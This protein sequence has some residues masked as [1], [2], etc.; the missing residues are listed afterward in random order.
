MNENTS[1]VRRHVAFAIKLAAVLVAVA[2]LLALGRR[3]GY[4][5][6]ESVMRA[7]NIIMGVGFAAYFNALPKLQQGIPVTTAPATATL[8]QSVLRVN[9]WVMTLTFIAFAAIWAF[10]PMDFTGIASMAVIGTGA[11]VT[12]GY[13]LWKGIAHDRSRS[14]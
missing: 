3:M 2:L 10:V 11:A 9:A 6:Q 7:Y 12:M 13:I 8:A 14:A 1:R 5:D 4:I